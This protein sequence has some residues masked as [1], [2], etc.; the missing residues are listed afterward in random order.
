MAKIEAFKVAGTGGEGKVRPAQTGCAQASPPGVKRSDKSGSLPKPGDLER[1]QR[2]LRTVAE[3]I[4]DDPAY[5]PIFVR[6]E[7]EIR[8]ELE[9]LSY[10][11][12]GRARAIARQSA[13]SSSS[14]RT[15]SSPPPSP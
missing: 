10:D 3:L 4:V 15:C 9:L 1:L 14:A 13:I 11:V 7:E 5:A 12:I 2:A 8:L 6:L